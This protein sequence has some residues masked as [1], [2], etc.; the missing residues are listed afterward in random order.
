MNMMDALGMRKKLGADSRA[1][2]T[3]INHF[4]YGATTAV[5]YSLAEWRVPLGPLAKGPIFG[6]LVWLV[7][8]LGL[9]PALG[10]LNPATKHPTS[11]NLLMLVVHLVWGL[12]VGVFVE[13]LL[14]EKKRVFGAILTASPLPQRDRA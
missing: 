7:S 14:S 2:L 8:Y 12:F 5:L 9:L 4:A 3:L 1:A 10:V 11:R 6:A 13:T